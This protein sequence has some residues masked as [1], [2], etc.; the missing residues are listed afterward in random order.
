MFTRDLQLS[1][2]RMY[3]THETIEDELERIISKCLAAQTVRGLMHT[4]G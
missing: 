4:P 1:P 2:W 3:Y